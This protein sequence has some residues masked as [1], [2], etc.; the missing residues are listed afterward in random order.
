[1]I[2]YGRHRLLPEDREALLNV[3]DSGWLTG[4]PA[5]ADFEAALEDVTQA[6]EGVACSTGTSALQLA[7]ELVD[8][9]PGAW[10]LVPPCTFVASAQAARYCGYRPVFVDCDEATGLL[11]PDALER[12]L[13]AADAEE[14]AVAAV[15]AVDLN[16][17]PAP[18]ERYL[19]VLRPRGLPLIRDGAHSLGAIDLD[20]KPVGADREGL[21]ATTFSFHPVKLI[22][23]AEGGAIALSCRE[24]AKRLRGLRSHAMVRNPERPAEYEVTDLGYNHRLSDLHAALGCAQLARLQSKIDERKQLADRY[25]NA[26]DGIDTMQWVGPRGGTKSAWH[27]ASILVDRQRR[28]SILEELR[29]RGIGAANHYPAAHKQPTF[30]SYGPFSGL[31]SSEAYCDRQ[32]TLPL[33]EGLTFSQ[34]DQVIHEV[35]RL[36]RPERA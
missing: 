25:Q 29:E 14:A 4:G 15:V 28:W 31:S 21:L 26:F 23:A 13:A 19:E 7:G 17:H 22:A 32:I 12:T 24:Q 11:C 3:L 9:P 18:V 36:V 1:M 35:L 2:P 34:Q 5:V 10:W 6:T 8:A 30:T 27:L 33:Y 16:G 20:G